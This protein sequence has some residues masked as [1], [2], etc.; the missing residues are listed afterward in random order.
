MPPKREGSYIFNSN[1]SAMVDDH[2]IH[3]DKGS[4]TEQHF[5]HLI[6]VAEQNNIFLLSNKGNSVALEK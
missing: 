1:Q 4:R 5:T 3:I 2:I 6:R